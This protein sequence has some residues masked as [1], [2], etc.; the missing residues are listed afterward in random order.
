MQT[1]SLTLQQLATTNETYD[2]DSQWF[3]GSVGAILYEIAPGASFLSQQQIASVMRAASKHFKRGRV[4]DV[5]IT[6]ERDG[7]V[8]FRVELP[9]ATRV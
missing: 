2:G 7:T 9:G 8:S 4:S 3:Q 1:C 6:V 5:T